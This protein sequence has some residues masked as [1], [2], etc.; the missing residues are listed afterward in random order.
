MVDPSQIEELE[1][2]MAIEA[3]RADHRRQ[4]EQER[5]IQNAII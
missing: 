2:H 1:M 5:Q 4:V 3:S